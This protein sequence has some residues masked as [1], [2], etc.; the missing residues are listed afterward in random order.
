MRGKLRGRV[1][2]DARVVHDA[3]FAHV[4]GTALVHEAAIVP[5]DGVARGPGVV[6]DARGLAGEVD[7]LLEEALGLCLV[8][9]GD[10]VG[11]AADRQGRAAGLRVGLDQGSQ[12][13]VLAVEAV[14]VVGAVFVL[15]SF[16]WL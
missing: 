4:P 8:E 2:R 5:D 15:A 3:G 16:A 9:A 11:V 12:G 13:R 1:A 7:E 6:V 14:A 10:A